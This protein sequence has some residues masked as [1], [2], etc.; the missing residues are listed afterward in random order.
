MLFAIHRHD[1]HRLRHALRWGA[2]PN[3][4]GLNGHPPLVH[5][6][7]CDWVA[8][9]RMLLENGARPNTGDDRA[10]LPLFQILELLNE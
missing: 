7:Q 8:G 10:F 4:R 3:I 1:M 9:C 2:D 5:A 6:I